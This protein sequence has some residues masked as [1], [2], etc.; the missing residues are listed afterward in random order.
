MQLLVSPIWRKLISRATVRCAGRRP[1]GRCLRSWRSACCADAGR[2]RLRGPPGTAQQSEPVGT[3]GGDRQSD[4][5]N[6]RGRRPAGQ[7]H[8]AAAEDVAGSIGGGSAELAKECWHAD[9][10]AGVGYRSGACRGTQRRISA[11]PGDCS[12]ATTG[13]SSLHGSAD[14]HHRMGRFAALLATGRSACGFCA[15]SCR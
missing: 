8:G 7:A 9:R 5:W 1:P 11:V 14:A 13:L 3:A 12:G 4:P 6:V 2:S 15:R 10:Q